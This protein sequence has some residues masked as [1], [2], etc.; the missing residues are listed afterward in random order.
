MSQS[1]LYAISLR[2]CR[3]GNMHLTHFIRGISENRPTDRPIALKILDLAENNITSG[4]DI[5]HLLSLVSLRSLTLDGNQIDDHLEQLWL[6]VVNSKSLNQL[7]MQRCGIF[8]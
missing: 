4:P 2:H 8:L 1:S 6:S 3:M 5:A 7:S